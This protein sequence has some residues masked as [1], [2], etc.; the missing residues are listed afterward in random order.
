MEDARTV[1]TCRTYS[2]STTALSSRAEAREERMVR[3]VRSSSVHTYN[4]G[5]ACQTLRRQSTLRTRRVIG[6]RVQ[7]LA[8]SRFCPMQVLSPATHALSRRSCK[9]GSRPNVEWEEH[10]GTY[11]L[12]YGRPTCKSN[13]EEKS[14]C[15]GSDR[16]PPASCI[17]RVAFHGP[18]QFPPYAGRPIQAGNPC[19]CH[20]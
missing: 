20:P 10:T 13:E 8:L 9:W 3:P 11:V 4:L 7:Q 5:C 19:I 17:A 12:P 1:C 2:D 6:N 18:L 14:Q 16:H 15:P